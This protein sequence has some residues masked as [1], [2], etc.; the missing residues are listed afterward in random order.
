MHQ[1]DSEKREPSVSKEQKPINENVRTIVKAS[2]VV[3]L[4]SGLTGVIYL[5]AR[6]NPKSFPDF[7]PPLQSEPEESAK[8]APQPSNK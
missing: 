8:E 3:A 4:V 5:A 6:D 2:F 7:V 1:D